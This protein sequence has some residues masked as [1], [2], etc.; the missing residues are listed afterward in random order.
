MCSYQP[1]LFE[2]IFIL[3]IS[4]TSVPSTAFR[5]K[6]NFLYAKKDDKDIVALNYKSLCFWTQK[7]LREISEN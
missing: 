6:I 2:P 3:N 7:V 4:S 1:R 5:Q